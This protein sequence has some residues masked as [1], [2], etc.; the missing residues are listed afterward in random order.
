[1]ASSRN[2]EEREH[3]DTWRLVDVDV[4]RVDLETETPETQDLL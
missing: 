4:D 1:M 2:I 3:S